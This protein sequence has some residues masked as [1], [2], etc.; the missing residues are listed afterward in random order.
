[1]APRPQKPDPADLPADGMRLFTVAE[2]SRRLGVSVHYVY[3]RIRG[4][5][6]PYVDL[7]MGRAKTRVR[8][9]HLQQLIDSLTHHTRD[10][11]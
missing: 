4:G 8:A 1:M 10:A 7:G 2:V 6:L 9:D 5:D 11:A 3:D